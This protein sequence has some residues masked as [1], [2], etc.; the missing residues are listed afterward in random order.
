MQPQRADTLRGIKLFAGIPPEQFLPLDRRCR[1]RRLA[2]DAHIVGYQ[3]ETTDV[4][5]V[6]QGRVRVTIFSSAGREVT[7][8]DF[9]VGDFFGELSAID[10]KPRSASVVALGE[11]VVAAMP[12]PA[13]RDVLLQYPS[14]MEAILKRLVGSVRML[15][16]RVL[17]FSTLAVRNRIHA[18]L[19]RLARGSGG[20]G[21][22]AT[23]TPLPT[24]AEIA[25]RVSTHREA[26][27]RELNELA[28]I[29]LVERQSQSLLIRDVPKLERMLRDVSGA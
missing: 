3:D 1:F 8:R 13:F 25:S 16:E 18:E 27:T 19:L 20:A 4:Y 29:G 14:V 12:A 21:Q 17:E 23:I 2:R 15:S 6:V 5:F 24:H 26:V 22:T 9:A 7:F 28:R 10:A 11:S